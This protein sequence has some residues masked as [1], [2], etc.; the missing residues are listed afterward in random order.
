MSETT[1]FDLKKI[2][3]TGLKVLLISV[4]TGLIIG[5]VIW[6]SL[7]TIDFSKSSGEVVSKGW[8]A[9]AGIV[10]ISLS[11]AVSSLVI[12]FGIFVLVLLVWRISGF[13]AQY[14][15]FQPEA[16]IVHQMIAP[17]ALIAGFM[18]A[19]PV[20]LPYAAV[21]IVKGKTSDLLTQIQQL[22]GLFTPSPVKYLGSTDTSNSEIKTKL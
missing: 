13:M 9:L 3:I 4:A 18:F 1:E 7:G 16:G 21:Q 17:V 2:S 8:S 6:F 15:S 5:L 14:P 19:S 20:L 22:S 11:S 10:G 12:L